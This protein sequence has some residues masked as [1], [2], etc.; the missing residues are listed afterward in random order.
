MDTRF[1]AVSLDDRDQYYELW[2]ATPQHSLDYTLA[3]L[4]GWQEYFNL[5]WQFAHGLCWIR[6]QKPKPLWWA[7]LGNWHSVDWTEIFAAFPKGEIQHFT[8]V[9]EVLADL[10]LE[11]LPDQIE[12]EEDRGQWEYLYLQ[13]DLANLAGNKFHKKRNHYNSYVKTYGE[14]D[15]RPVNDAQV[16]DVLGVQHHWC[17][18]H[19]CTDSPSLLAENEAIIRVLTH[20]NA[21]RKMAGGSLFIDGQ[22][23]AFSIGEALDQE[24]LGVHFEKGLTG[25]KGIYQ[26]MNLQFA[27]HAGE[28][29]KWLDRAQD[30]DEEGLRQAKMTYMPAGFLHKFKARIES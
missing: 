15:Y 30:L 27:A 9:P 3:N 12:L 20:W 11:A 14:P 22:M 23:V 4:W 24:M 18:W 2:D 1:T 25:Y 19:E 13:K 28:G 10:W 29:F 5:E 8:R 16:V 6:Q 17:Q 7:P 21:F 26:A